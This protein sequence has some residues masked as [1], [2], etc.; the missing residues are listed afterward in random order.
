MLFETTPLRE[1]VVAISLVAQAADIMPQVT[2]KLQ[3][4]C[5]RSFSL[6]L[7]ARLPLHDLKADSGKKLGQS[8]RVIQQSARQPRFP[9][10]EPAD[11]DSADGAARIRVREP[12]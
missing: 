2:G 5:A 6:Y 1:R 8:G 7:T 10:L 9:F 3:K 4:Y 11:T 12:T